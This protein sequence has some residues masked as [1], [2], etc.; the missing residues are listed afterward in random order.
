[1]RNQ[2]GISG[3]VMAV[4]MG[5]FTSAWADSKAL[6]WLESFRKSDS[7]LSMGFVQTL[8]DAQGEIL[9]RQEGRLEVLPPNR[10]V[11]RYSSPYELEFGS[12]GV[13]VWHWDHDLAQITVRDARKVIAGTPLA[14]MLDLDQDLP[15][16]VL[17]DQWLG[18]VPEG[19]SAQFAEL[20]MRMGPDGPRELYLTDFLD[21]KTRVVFDNYRKPDPKVDPRF[22]KVGP[23]V[24]VVDERDQP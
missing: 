20:R 7:G 10:F 21:Q 1:M 15:V 8:T 17:A 2:A 23:E 3:L 9:E 6:E 13:L 22:P 12:N 16:K 19:D 18:W 4:L 14:L 24:L 5:M 11:W